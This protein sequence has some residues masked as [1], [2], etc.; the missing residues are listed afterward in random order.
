MEPF[1]HTARVLFTLLAISTLSACGDS[2]SPTTAP[3]EDIPNS[4]NSSSFIQATGNT[5]LTIP[6]PTEACQTPLAVELINTDAHSE[7]PLSETH[8]ELLLKCSAE[9]SSIHAY[10]QLLSPDNRLA[11]RSTEIAPIE[12]LINFESPHVHPIDITP[13][14]NTLVSVNTAAH[15]LEVWN[16][17]GTSINPII[18]IPVGLDPVSVRVR[19]DSE[20]WVVN[21]MSDSVSIVNLDSQTVTQTLKTLNE[22]SD[23]VF[24]GS[25]RAFVSV[26]EANSINVFDL[27][28]LNTD[29][30]IIKIAGEEPRSLSVSTDGNTVYAGIYES[31][32]STTFSGARG[33]G[34]PIIRDES[35]L[36]NDVAIINS[37]SLEVTYRRRLMNM[38][39]AISVNPNTQEVF[40]VGTEAANLIAGEPALNGKF[41]TVNMAK[42][43]GPGLNNATIK[44]LNPHLDYTTATVSSSLREQSLGDPRSIVWQQNGQRAFIAGMGSNNIA[45]I[46]NNGARIAHFDV[47]QG[48]TGIALKEAANIGFVMNKFAGSISIINLNTL[49]Q[50]SEVEFDDPTP[51]AIKEGRPFIYDT[52]LTSGTGHT[53][54]ASCHVDSRTDRLG[55][56]LSDEQNTP[57]TIPAGPNIVPGNATGTATFSSNKTI[58]LTQ[59][60]LD[61]M[62]HPRFHWRGDK[63]SIDD[64]NDT[65][66]NL[67]GRESV[68][69]P[70]QMD[71]MKGFLRTLWLPPNPYRRIDNSR[72]NSITLSNGITVTSNLINSDATD[73]L[74]GGFGRDCLGCHSGQG[75]TRNNA[76][77]S[78]NG[79]GLPNLHLIAPA[80]PGFYDKVGLIDGLSG[81]GFFH[82]G[83]SNLF[84]SSRG[85]N[86]PHIAEIL[87]LEGPEG[88]LVGNEVRKAPH[89][90]VGQQVTINSNPTAAQL[91]R[92]DQLINIANMSSWAE[93]VAHSK[94]N[95][96]HRGFVLQ[97]GENFTADAVGET[98]TKASL[99]SEAT[100][101]NPVTFTIVAKGMSTRLALDSNLNGTLNHDEDSN[102]G[103]DTS[104]NS[105][106]PTIDGS[107]SEW[108]SAQS[109]GVDGDDINI[110][111]S[112]AD[113]L[114]AWIAN[115]SSN[116]Y[117]A[118]LNDGPIDNDTWWP[119]QLYI[120]TDGDASTGFQS[121]NGLGAEFILEA[122]YLM[123]YTGT[124]SNW[125]WS[126]ETPNV[127]IKNNNSAEFS[128]NLQSLGNPSRFNYFFRTNNEPFIG[129][130]DEAG[131]DLIP[132]SGISTYKLN[133]ASN[134]GT[135]VS[136][137][138]TPTLDGSLDDW[139]QAV[140]F[141]PDGNDISMT[142]AQA[143]WLEA[144]MAHDSDNLYLAYTNDGPINYDTWWPWQIY[145]DTDNTLDTGFKIDG[146]GAD[147]M[148]EGS[149]IVK[150]TGDGESWSWQWM[151]TATSGKAQSQV[152]LSIPKSVL[153]AIGLFKVQ[154]KT[155]NF[156]FT[157]DFS[158]FGSD[159]YE[160][161]QTSM[162]YNASP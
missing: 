4:I 126:F 82:D 132:N 136:N 122:S 94:I 153:G 10:Q 116:L 128:I 120:D 26:S 2:D 146:M 46:D 74:R 142:N 35:I 23:V 38:V 72:P 103:S 134:D 108:S 55:W 112:K 48:P 77:T 130:F 61:I 45:V 57:I 143:D 32:N 6:K 84:E 137:I 104:S 34:N 118:Y 99:L 42:F 127:G 97:Q 47:G 114:E 107:L 49:S 39:M 151:A 50:I 62:E 36:D 115:D 21:H 17:S 110:A 102:N 67:M 138:L 75:N 29:P 18:S 131:V 79:F 19:N 65:F 15:T 76:A 139:S 91:T 71:K 159:S 25:N 87:T 90:G 129:D 78:Q 92:L 5:V 140:S 96:S 161:N 51:L 56:Q 24:A 7:A 66:V 150:Y 27:N 145:L 119:W 158:A 105:F 111:N 133:A 12:G 124:G 41:I 22:P 113:I 37:T 33:S 125:S 14:G 152:E 53:S 154:M 160:G 121:N 28:N 11:R 98:A 156:A 69:T 106:T 157:N 9:R 148:V 8:K 1:T 89:A 117:I 109:I 3:V 80:F 144:W 123:K 31:G 147:F 162:E 93:L 135:V 85:A 13:N 43:S 73:A 141:G 52:H 68:I 70:T 81:F 54:C 88:P 155:R 20:A 100:N 40:A 101:G 30:T 44:D 60:L 86:F 95:G 83:T 59:T 16:I 64:F 63:E 58:M 149:S